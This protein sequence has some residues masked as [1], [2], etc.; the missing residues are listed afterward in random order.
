MYR[1]F[2]GKKPLEIDLTPPIS[3]KTPNDVRA[4]FRKTAFGRDRVDTKFGTE[5]LQ[6]GKKMFKYASATFAIGLLLAGL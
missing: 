2:P 6:K 3:S 5:R 1:N 4:L